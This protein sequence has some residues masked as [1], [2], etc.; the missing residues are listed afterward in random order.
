MHAVARGKADA[1][2][3]LLERGADANQREIS[4]VS[5]LSYA[6]GLGDLEIFQI[7][8]EKGAKLDAATDGVKALMIAVLAKDVGDRGAMTFLLEHG[9]DVNAADE[10]G[11]T[12]L[13][14]TVFSAAMGGRY[15]HLGIA[16]AQLENARFLIER[17]A[18]VNQKN[19]GGATALM[20]IA[21]AYYD[22]ASDFAQLLLDN[23]ADV[24]ATD[25]EGCSALFDA[26]TPEVRNVPE[27][28]KIMRLLIERGADVNVVYTGKD[29]LLRMKT[30]DTPLILAARQPNMGEAVKLLLAAGADVNACN[31][32]G[33][34]ALSIAAGQGHGEIAALLRQA[35][36]RDDASTRP[37]LREVDNQLLRAA[38]EADVQAL[39]QLLD[40][41][42]N[43]NAAFA[44]G[45][46]PLTQA[47]RRGYLE[48]VRLLLA[49]G[50][51]AS[52][53]NALYAAVF[54]GHDEIISLLL[55]SGANIN[56]C[57]GVD[58]E[59]PLHFAARM[60]RTALVRLLVEH[61]ADVNVHDSG[62]V[63]PLIKA[64]LW[65]RQDIACYL[66]KKGADIHT[67][68][69]NPI[70]S[71]PLIVAARQCQ[72]DM[73]K[74]LV[75]KGV[76]VNVRDCMGCTPL[77][78]AAAQSKDSA[79]ARRYA[80]IVQF[81][82]EHGADVNARDD[83]GG[84]VLFHAAKSPRNAVTRLLKEAGAL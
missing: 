9:V 74:L 50:A 36:A 10:D 32:H 73:V 26:C 80:P 44:G 79:D 78:L 8:L 7:L 18:D 40:E 39:Q 14:H 37:V 41:G 75:E 82:I 4:G 52:A 22:G 68:S 64:L 84:S 61:G 48:N 45:G 63:T 30:G 69:R 3:L 65:Q 42:A 54:E 51:D 24:N 1:V 31:A 27:T 33:D 71:A 21:G 62:G 28:L 47:I 60:D 38:G 46:T 23:G 53:G 5:A 83:D 55:E 58:G 12:A 76:D 35:G 59:G 66:I 2:R 17:G 29:T 49:R 11:D 19:N 56:E 72:L 20:A 81:L 15:K 57:D 34:T 70:E 25:H 77:M 13:H 43:V 67:I 16:E 6:A